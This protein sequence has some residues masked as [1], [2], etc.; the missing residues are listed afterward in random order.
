MNTNVSWIEHSDTDW[1]ESIHDRKNTTSGCFLVLTIWYPT[2]VKS[3]TSSYFLLQ[4]L[5]ILQPIVVAH[6]CFG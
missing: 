5:K 1:A 6:N 3:K 4:K 2:I